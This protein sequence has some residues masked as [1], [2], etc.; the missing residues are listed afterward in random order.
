MLESVFN[1]NFVKKIPRLFIQLCNFSTSYI[2]FIF[3]FESFITTTL[4]KFSIGRHLKSF[5]INNIKDR[6]N[7]QLWWHQTNNFPLHNWAPLERWFSGPESDRR[8]VRINY[9][10]R[11]GQTKMF[12]TN[13]EAIDIQLGSTFEILSNQF[14]AVIISNKKVSPRYQRHFLNSWEPHCMYISTS[15]I[16][17]IITD[18][19]KITKDL[20]SLPGKCYY[21]II[22]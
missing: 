19:F 13:P 22:Q 1:G 3:I 18:C 9:S 10:L 21:R 20:V 7:C 6:T 5:P 12:S 11:M 2:I 4:E 15:M 14:S 16:A 8:K 17:P